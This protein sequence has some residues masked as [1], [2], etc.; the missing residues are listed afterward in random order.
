MDRRFCGAQHIAITYQQALPIWAPAC[1]MCTEMTSLMVKVVEFP[2]GGATRLMQSHSEPKVFWQDWDLTQQSAVCRAEGWCGGWGRPRS[3]RGQP[4][5]H[6]QH[7]HR[8]LAREEALTVPSSWGKAP[9]LQR[10]W[11][12]DEI[13]SETRMLPAVLAIED[14]KLFIQ[15]LLHGGGLLFEEN[16]RIFHMH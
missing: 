4:G 9:L 16:K 11:I 8:K 13:S 10:W 2:G 12:M 15:S 6:W 3:P 7:Y 1:P 14:D 5:H